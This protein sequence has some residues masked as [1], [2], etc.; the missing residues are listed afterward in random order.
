MK[1]IEEGD[2]VS[3]EVEAKLESG[4]QCIPNKENAV[5]FVVGEGKFFPNLENQLINMKEGDKKEIILEP[6]DAF[7]PHHNELVLEAPRSSFRSDFDPVVGMRLKI[8]A[9]SGKV[10]YGSIT[11]ITNEAIT[12]DLNHPLAGKKIVFKITILTIEK[13]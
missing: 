6:N 2:K 5:E 4:E 13:K 12:L 8:D 7:G 1:I 10:F 11:E 9:P 3:I